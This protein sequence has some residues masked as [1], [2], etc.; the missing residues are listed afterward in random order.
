MEFARVK[1]VRSV[2]GLEKGANFAQLPLLDFAS[3]GK[4]VHS[5]E[6][7]T[8]A[9]RRRDRDSGIESK[10]LRPEP[11]APVLKPAYRESPGNRPQRPEQFQAQKESGA[12]PNLRPAGGAAV[13]RWRSRPEPRQI[14][15]T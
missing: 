10:R 7:L 2:N 13:N 15:W 14:Q 11:G 12:C 9:R 4:L 6:G 5:Q 1:R 3:A 8:K